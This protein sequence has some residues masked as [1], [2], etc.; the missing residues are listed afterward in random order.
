MLPVPSSAK[1]ARQVHHL[2]GLFWLPLTSI[3]FDS[4]VQWEPFL[5]GAVIDLKFQCFGICL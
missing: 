2:L 5:C 1:F 4:L 3:T